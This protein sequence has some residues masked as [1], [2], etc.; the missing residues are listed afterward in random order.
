MRAMTYAHLL[1]EVNQAHTIRHQLYVNLEKQFKQKVKVVALFTSFSMPVLIQDVDADML[2]EVLQN[3]PLNGKELVLLINSPGGEA[4]PAERI[5]NICRSYSNGKFCVIVP[6]MAKSA[7]TMICL[8]A[9]KIGMS[10]TSELGPIDPQIAI[11]DE[12]GNV[13]KYLAAHE[14]IESY[15]ELMSKANRTRGR[16][17]PFL[18]QLARYD[19]RDIRRI[20]SAQELSKSIAVKC[21]QSSV[22]ANRRAKQIENRIKPFLD[23]KYTKVH[24][25]G[26]YHDLAKKCGLNVELHDTMS[27]VW[28]IVWKLYVRLNYVVTHSAAKVIESSDDYWIAPLQ[29]V[30]ASTEVGTID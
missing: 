15:N 1:A 12:R 19:A 14:I 22:F 26:I 28:R 30:A 21:L 13:I 24:G 10:R 7:A 25:R 4:L 17:D 11:Y 5:V 9:N 2:E 23:P 29:Q 20:R 3:T 27:E 8:G 18:Q 6:K 16:V